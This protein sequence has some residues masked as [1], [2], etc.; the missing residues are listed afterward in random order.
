MIAFQSYFMC[1]EILIF[2]PYTIFFHPDY[3]VGPGITPS[4][5]LR[6][7]GYTTGGESHPALK[8]LIQLSTVYSQIFCLSIHTRKDY[9]SPAEGKENRGPA[10]QND[11][12]AEN[13]FSYRLAP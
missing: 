1:A 7:V 2:S 3:T 4:H 8:I 5:A 13:G 10:K 6:L 12:S 11:R 9:P